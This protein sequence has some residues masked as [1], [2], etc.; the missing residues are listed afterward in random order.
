MT[1]PALIADRYELIDDPF[2]GSMGEVFRAYDTRLDR[3]VA[4][5]V[6]HRDLLGGD[7]ET[8]LVRRFRREARLTAKAA[9]PGVPEIFDIGVDQNRHYVVMEL[10]QGATL[11]DLLNEVQPLPDGWA[12][13]I[14][15]QISAVLACTHAVALIHRDLKPDNV[16]LCVDGTVKVIDFGVAILADMNPSSRLTPPGATAGD[17]RYQA[18]E[19]FLGLATPQSDLF[20]LGRVI[21]DMLRDDPSAPDALVALSEQLVQVSPEQRPVN[22]TEVFGRL[23]PLL[24][25]LA[26]LPGFV[27]SG[28]PDALRMYD[29]TLR[30]LPAPLGERCAPV[31]A[32]YEVLTPRQARARAEVYAADGRFNLAVRLLDDAIAAADPAD[33]IVTDLRRDL[34]AVLVDAGDA[35]RAVD[36][37]AVAVKALAGRVAPTHPALSSLRL[38]MA[39]G[40]AVLGEL[41]QARDVYESLIDDFVTAGGSTSAEHVVAVCELA[42][43]LAIQGDAG[44]AEDLLVKVLDVP[45]VPSCVGRVRELLAAV[46]Q[47]RHP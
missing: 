46:R 16:M 21:Q 32:S 20:S 34:A 26:S 8:E 6:I 38:S 35:R 45:P 18:P 4:V 15:A 3:E 47:T 5:K 36:A 23:K 40:H 29:E 33:R 30:L 27:T 24:G 1:S 17:A 25:R 13:F 31:H 11:R 37:C 44:H 19:R 28:R 22:A 12:A 41:R 43:L 10:V 39:R 2:R 14:A 7:L 42:A 9:H